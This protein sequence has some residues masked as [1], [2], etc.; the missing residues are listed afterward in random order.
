MSS[1]KFRTTETSLTA[2]AASAAKSAKPQVKVTFGKAYITACRSNTDAD[3]LRSGFMQRLV[4]IESEVSELKRLLLALNQL[5]AVK[6]VA[7][8]V[9]KARA[10]SSP[11]GKLSNDLDFD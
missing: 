8:A 2:P 10:H 5:P 7:A 4:E 3:S 1:K 6:K 11:R 9:P